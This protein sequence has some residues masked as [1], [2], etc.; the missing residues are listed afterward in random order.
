MSITLP[1]HLLPAR[2][3]SHVKDA[4]GAVVADCPKAAAHADEVAAALNERAALQ[5]QVQA[6]TGERDR[7]RPLASHVRDADRNRSWMWAR[8]AEITLPV[9]AVFDGDLGAHVVRDRGGMYVALMASAANADTIASSLNDRAALQAEVAN[10]TAERDRL[11]S[12][13][14]TADSRCVATLAPTSEHRTPAL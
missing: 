6:L 2:T 9:Q 11:R 4:A 12:L 14:T 7:L 3:R 5:T 13:A 10:L 1:V 8:M